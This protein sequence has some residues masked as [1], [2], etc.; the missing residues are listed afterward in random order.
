[1]FKITIDDRDFRGD[2][3][4]L[5]A[6]LKD[7]SPVMRGVAGIMM[8]A[9][10]ENFEQ[11]GRPKW[12]SLAPSTIKQRQKAGHEGKMLQISAG[13]LKSSISRKHDENSA[14]VGTNKIYARIHQLGG[15]A[16]RGKKVTIPARPYLKLTDGDLNDVR[17][18]IK[19]HLNKI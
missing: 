12:P 10:E 14:T 8:N 18:F 11:E 4:R 9:V 7:M 17:E 6:R 5:T 13:G 2:L 16:G 15:K 19:D 1:M 3:N